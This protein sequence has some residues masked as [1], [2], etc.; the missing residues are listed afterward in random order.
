MFI[1]CL[2][3]QEQNASGL[4]LIAEKLPV[5]LNNETH[6]EK[7]EILAY[8]YSESVSKIKVSMI[9]DYSAI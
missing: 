8:L 9:R 7:I 4:L 2:L 5:I 6:S 1:S 3:P